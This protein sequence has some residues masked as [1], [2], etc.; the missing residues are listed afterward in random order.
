MAS[1]DADYR[2]CPSEWRMARTD[3]R[4]PKLFFP[5]SIAEGQQGVLPL[6]CWHETCAPPGKHL[7][8]KPRTLFTRL[9][10]RTTSKGNGM[11]SAARE[12][13]R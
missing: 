11:L 4:S 5:Q 1:N 12:N 10:P 7:E 8:P 2:G 9:G 3:C 6:A 13:R